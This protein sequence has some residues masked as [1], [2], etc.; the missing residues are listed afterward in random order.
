[1]GKRYL[2]LGHKE[3][4]KPTKKS[5]VALTIEFAVPKINKQGYVCKLQGS[6]KGCSKKAR[7]QNISANHMTFRQD[8]RPHDSP[9]GVPGLR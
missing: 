4:R 3:G 1:M 2:T 8:L 6:Q 9:L 7:H 5:A